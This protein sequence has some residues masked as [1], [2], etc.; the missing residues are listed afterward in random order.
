MALVA[1]TDEKSRLALQNHAVQQAPRKSGQDLAGAEGDVIR[2]KQIML[3]IVRVWD[4]GTT[5]ARK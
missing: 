4:E 5:S 2:E 1:R 3:Y